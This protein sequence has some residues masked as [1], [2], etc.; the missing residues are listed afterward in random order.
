MSVMVI[1]ARFWSGARPVEVSSQW[2]YGRSATQTGPSTW[3]PSV[4]GAVPDSSATESGGA[5][6]V[7][8][9]VVV[10]VRGGSSSSPG[11]W[12]SAAGAGGG[13]DGRV[14]VVA[15]RVVVVAGAWQLPPSDTVLDALPTKPSLHTPWTERLALVAEPLIPDCTAEP[16]PFGAIGLDGPVDELA[17]GVLP[18]TVTVTGRFGSRCRSS[19]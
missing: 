19:T 9:A 4:S 8:G 7:A 16:W 15:G 17:L 18:V 13:G 11:A 14:V 3:N 10:V 6:V 12:S 2:M 1:V 5:V